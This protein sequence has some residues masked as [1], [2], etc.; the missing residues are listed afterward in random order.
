MNIYERTFIAMVRTCLTYMQKNETQWRSIPVLVDLYNRLVEL[1][2]DIVRYEQMQQAVSPQAEIAQRQEDAVVL[3]KSYYRLSRRLLLYAQNTNNVLL[4]KQ[5]DISETKLKAKNAN[6]LIIA[7]TGILG[8]AREHL[9]DAT[10]YQINA[11]ELNNLEAILIRFK[12]RPAALLHVGNES[13]R[14]TRELK[15]TLIEVRKV[16]QKLDFGMDGMVT[17]QNFIDGWND[18]RRIKSRPLPKKKDNTDPLVDEK[19][20]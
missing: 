19:N 11:E 4:A 1:E 6:D 10:D 9:K 7:C 16:I 15:N 12:M 14:A 5:T 8:F 3:A 18:V 13:R 2:A 20:E 17:D